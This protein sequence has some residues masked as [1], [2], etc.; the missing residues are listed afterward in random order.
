MDRSGC[1]VGAVAWLAGRDGVPGPF[2]DVKRFAEAGRFEERN[3][4]G[5]SSEAGAGRSSRS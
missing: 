5:G 3:N 4:E 1:L 2:D